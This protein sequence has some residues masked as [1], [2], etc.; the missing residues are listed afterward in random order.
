[1]STIQ[2]IN[3]ET[4]SHNKY[5]LQA[6][7][8]QQ[9]DKEGQLQDKENEVYIRPDAAT[10][11]LVDKKSEIFLLT[12]QFRLPTFL[13]GNDTGYLTETCAGLIADNETPETTIHREVEE[14]T[15]YKLKNLEKVA[16][17]YSAPGG[18]T[19]YVHLFIGEIDLQ[20]DHTDGGGLPEEGENI[21]LIRLTFNQARD[22]LKRSVIK[23]AKTLILL[24]HFFLKL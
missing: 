22:E 11:L 12:R 7:K 10:V 16:A 13:N 4:I 8:F 17:V 5:T 3:R 18:L 15:G 14:E 20:A 23:D 9:P 24:Q 1:M 2:I 21:G 6:I 19:E